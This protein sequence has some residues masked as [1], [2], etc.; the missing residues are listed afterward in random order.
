MRESA[1][2]LYEAEETIRH[3]QSQ[4]H[5]FDRRADIA[6]NEI[7][8]A[9]LARAQIASRAIAELK[10]LLPPAIAQAQKG[11]PALLRMILRASR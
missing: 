10:K 11:K 9:A 4:A 6:R 2:E 7:A 1:R 8:K 5:S 3:M